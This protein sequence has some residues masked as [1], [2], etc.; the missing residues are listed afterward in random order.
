MKKINFIFF[1]PFVK[2]F[3]KVL[4]ILISKLLFV[5]IYSSVIVLANKTYSHLL[6]SNKDAAKVRPKGLL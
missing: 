1:F 3:L 4:I 5:G 6:R 2:L